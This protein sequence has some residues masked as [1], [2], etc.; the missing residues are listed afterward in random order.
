M[1]VEVAELAAEAITEVSEVE[2]AIS[3]EAVTNSESDVDSPISEQLV[4]T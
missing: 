3:G 1:V 4:G 2:V